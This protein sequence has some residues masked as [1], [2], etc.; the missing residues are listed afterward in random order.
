M[1]VVAGRDR[2]L[3]YTR[4]DGCRAWLA[5]GMIPL[6]RMAALLEAFGSYEAI[7]DRF[8]SQGPSVLRGCVN[9]GQLALLGERA[10]PDAMHEMMLIMQRL[11][12]GLL[13]PDDSAYPEALRNIQDPPSLLFCRGN[14]ACLS[15]RLIAM[16]GSR[17]A[18]RT[19][20]R[21]TYAIAKELSANGVSIVSGLAMG[22][23]TAA[24]KG[25]LEGGTPVI[26][27]AACGLD[28]D[29]PAANHGLKEQIIAA[30]G[31]LISEYPPGTLP[32][33]HHFAVRNRIMS[34]LSSAVLMMEGSIR[35]GSMLTVQH[36]LD[37]GREVY[38]Y[39]GEPGT[40]WAEGA[41]QLLREGANYFAS[42][43]DVL[44]DMGW[45]IEAPQEEPRKLP[46]LTPEQQRVYALLQ[47]GELSF[48]E[49]ATASGLEAQTLSAVLTM[50]KIMG[51]VE[52]LPGKV[53]KTAKAV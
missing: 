50:L 30:G 21:A 36:A 4:E 45:F 46:S 53:Y 28:V 39:P 37:Q 31:A 7:Y 38:A 32:L 2:P 9:E 8:R 6:S 42:A 17:K 20:E 52:D 16:V 41:H 25:G 24:L 27:V 13:A 22:I 3:R 18:S 44:E 29:Y 14:P 33:R 11:E 51:L 15:G 47:R 5:H 43:R 40:V 34:G 19:G 12:M 48:D 26:G 1:L 23:D 35:S 10:Q 49:L